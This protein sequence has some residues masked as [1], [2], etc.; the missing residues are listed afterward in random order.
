MSGQRQFAMGSKQ[1]GDRRKNTFSITCCECAKTDHFV[2]SSYS[3]L[4]ASE[5][6]ARHFAAKGWDVGKRPSHDVCPACQQAA[7]HR[8]RAKL[9]VVPDAP[10]AP[11]GALSFIPAPKEEPQPMTFVAQKNPLTPGPLSADPPRQMSREDKRLVYG[12][13]D[14]HYLDE[15]RGYDS[16]WTDERIAK[17][18]GVPRAWVSNVRAEMFGEAEGNG[19]IRRLLAEVI[20][21]K[22][23]GVALMERANEIQKEIASLMPKRSAA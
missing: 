14:E 17:D 12:K 2:A 10:A 18:L 6:V 9:S 4:M 15:V 23:Q 8:R 19:E 3:G 20:E 7:R 16:G 13:I 21:L 1:V 11:V 22:A 5:V